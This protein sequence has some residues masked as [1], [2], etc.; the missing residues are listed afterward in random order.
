MLG[1]K[2]YDILNSIQGHPVKMYS[3]VQW[4]L[5]PRRTPCIFIIYKLRTMH[6]VILLL[7]V[8]VPKLIIIAI[9]INFRTYVPKTF[10]ECKYCIVSCMYTA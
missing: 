5:L 2:S 3:I 7:H 4:Y 8:D 10:M 1:K 6:K 9:I